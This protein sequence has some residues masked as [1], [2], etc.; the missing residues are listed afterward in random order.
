[1]KRHPVRL[2][3]GGRASY[4]IIT[5]RQDDEAQDFRE[6]GLVRGARIAAVVTVFSLACFDGAPTFPESSPVQLES[7]PLLSGGKGVLVSAAYDRFFLKARLDPT[8][9]VIER[10]WTNFRV[11]VD[12]A[13]VDSWR[14][15]NTRIGFRVPRLASTTLAI[16][17]VGGPPATA[18]LTAR[19]LGSL[20]LGRLNDPCGSTGIPRLVP[21]GLEVIW[22]GTWCPLGRGE[23]FPVEGFLNGYA[24]IR[25]AVPGPEMTFVPGAHE[26]ATRDS[27]P[28]SA[29][30]SFDP[31]RTILELPGTFGTG[32]ATWVW[33]L[34]VDP[35]PIEPIECLPEGSWGGT[36]LAEVAPGVCIA[37]HIGSGHFM[38]NGVVIDE[39]CQIGFL[40]PSF[41]VSS[42]GVAVLKDLAV[43]GD[44]W[45]IFDASGQITHRITSYER[46]T[47]AAFSPDGELLYVLAAL[48]DGSG[49]VLD[50][51]NSVSGELLDRVE[52]DSSNMAAGG[53]HVEGDDLYLSRMVTVDGNQQLR[54]ERWNR[55]DL[56]L[57]RAIAMGPASF[58][59]NTTGVQVE[60]LPAADGSRVHMVG[61]IEDNLGVFGYTV[62]FE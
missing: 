55:A 46:V 62:D 2:A 28:T 45:P 50:V 9:A 40:G 41:R 6:G 23:G 18:S 49:W 10:R 34:G 36:A 54:V 51:R 32:S 47:G 44:F 13:E 37:F 25:P 19:A 42:M 11:E 35:Q 7:T 12:G 60:L 20:F 26:L 39:C 17:A 16:D 3:T 27:T 38:R 14:I 61:W 33:S 8:G 53:V 59:S 31:N 22:S 56:T 30:T 5:I 4:I 1:M 58:G 29:G 21:V 57:D 15:D 43:R 52:L 48:T 24:S